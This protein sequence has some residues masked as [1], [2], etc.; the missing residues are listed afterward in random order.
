MVTARP[1]S[2]GQRL[3]LWLRTR[4]PLYLGTAGWLVR[5]IA[6]YSPRGLALLAAITVV[7]VLSK[8][9]TFGALLVFATARLGSG[10]A[11]FQDLTI[12]VG[13]ETRDTVAWGALILGLAVLMAVSTFWAGR[14]RV[15]LGRQYALH[16]VRAVM[17]RLSG[18]SATSAS[19]RSKASDP[20]YVRR[21][22]GG[23][24][25]LLIRTV[26]PLT[27]A[28]MPL[29][30]LVVSAVL[31][32]AISARLTAL[33][34]VLAVAYALPFYRVN[35]R[36]VRASSKRESTTPAFSRLSRSVAGTAVLEQYNRPELVDRY[37]QSHEVTQHLDTLETLL[38]SKYH[39]QRLN[40][41]FLGVAALVMV[42]Y[43][44]TVNTSPTS[45][46]LNLIAFLAVARLA[47]ASISQLG[48]AF[49]G[50]NRFLPQ[51][52]R[53]VN[54]CRNGLLAAK[55][56]SARPE[57]AQLRVRVR[58]RSATPLSAPDVLTV[59]AGDV[60]TCVQPFPVDGARF[61]PWWAV[62]SGSRRVPAQ[63]QAF[64]AADSRTLPPLPLDELLRPSAGAPAGAEQAVE[65][66]LSRTG[67]AEE[68]HALRRLADDA[69]PGS[70]SP[71]LRLVSVLA[72]GVALGRR[73]LVL[74]RKDWDAVAPAERAALRA[75]LD[76]VLLL[77]TSGPARS[78]AA[79]SDLVVVL[80]QEAV[81]GFGDV[82]WW[83]RSQPA[84]QQW[85]AG[86][87]TQMGTLRAPVDD[88]D[89]DDE[90]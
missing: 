83:R 88:D 21:L 35:R 71:L 75:A 2:G 16:A 27:G 30:Q 76:D 34:A 73:T 62:L 20:A 29:L 52:Q 51:F 74:S 45:R 68:A 70:M 56:P 78:A 53:Y 40:D 60:V 31:L 5:D 12:R 80:D 10:T 37:L 4:L 87:G 67:V 38:T 84:A 22:I 6:R 72:P 11:K 24:A 14:L 32:V 18:A 81:L 55:G 82:A 44:A 57:D 9:A 58:V 66:L 41:V 49:V 85:F 63:E 54:F 43:M 3:S 69:A 28:L 48:R 64:L 50:F 1:P 47:Y 90:L 42:V 26:Q 36:V 61:R 13:D 39:V 7:S 33:L 86:R 59:G 89:E 15:R 65:D 17:E 8:V 25:M 77:V 19:F 46:A 23:D 79:D